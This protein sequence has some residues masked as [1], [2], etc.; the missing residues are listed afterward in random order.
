[1]KYDYIVIGAGASG[2]SFAALMEK[3][4]FSVAV[5]EAHS[6][7]GGCSSYFERNGFTFDAGATTLSGLKPGRPLANLIKTLDLNLQLISI[8]PGLVSILPSK[9]IHR[10]QDSKKWM[11]ELHKNFTQIKH[12]K[13]WNKFSAIELKG[14]KLSN[15]FKK[16]PLRKMK[17]LGSFFNPRILGGIQALPYLLKSVAQELQ[18]QGI[19]DPEYIKMI[20]ELLFITAQNNSQDTP[21][22][23]GAMGLCYPEDTSYAMGGMKAFA[24]A[25]AKKCS[26]L[27]YK[28]KVQKIC[29]L[30]NGAGGYLIETDQ[31]NF[32]GETVVSTIPFWN[33]QI[34]FDAPEIKEFYNSKQMPDANDCWSAFMIY[35]TIPLDESRSSLYYQIHTDEIP[36]CGTHSFFVSLSH[37]TDT[38]RSINGRQVVTISTHTKAL[39]WPALNRL[40]YKEKKEACSQFILNVF[41]EKFNL[42]DSDLQNIFTGSPTTFVKYTNRY[43]GLVGGIPHSLK[44][45]P[46]NYLVARSPVKNF[47]MIGDTQYP[48][49]GIASVVLGAQNLADYLSSE[50]NLGLKK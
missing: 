20:D 32:A 43:Q 12:E 45:N 9:K 10:Y 50:N 23:M 26:N 24:N 18:D 4:G 35:L 6:L 44:R 27:F 37:P 49:Q 39:A 36:H 47:Y 19:S 8:D 5:L 29:P 3:K 16:I 31:G 28:T 22:L 33:H 13:I 17:D 15:D 25:L 30:E 1:M 40:D 14:W 34:L 2:M 7:P 46:L 42:Q 48:G 38:S 21:L 11:A 41:K